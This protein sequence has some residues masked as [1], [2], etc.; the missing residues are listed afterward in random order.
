MITNQEI[1]QRIFHLE[2]NLIHFE[3]RLMQNDREM[4]P[5]EVEIAFDMIDFINREIIWLRGNL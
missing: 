2:V 4:E 1:I 5:N 3:T